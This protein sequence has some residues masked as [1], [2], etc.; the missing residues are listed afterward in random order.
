[1]SESEAAGRLAKMP[2]MVEAAATNPVQFVGVPRLNENGFRTGLLDIVELR[3][4]NNPMAQNIQNA[5]SLTLFSCETTVS[6]THV[7]AFCCL[8]LQYA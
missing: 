4:A 5:L 8:H 1:M 6:L 2:G 3:I 7:V